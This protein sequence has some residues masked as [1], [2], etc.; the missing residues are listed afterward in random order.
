MPDTQT[1]SVLDEL[2]HELAASVRRASSAAADAQ[3]VAQLDVMRSAIE[4]A[5]GPIAECMSVLM[6][7]PLL[8]VPEE[9]S[10]TLAERKEWVAAQIE[11]LREAFASDPGSI[12]KASLWRDTKNAFEKLRDELLNARAA[13]YESLVDGFAAGD[14]ELLQTL[15]PRTA[16]TREYREAI[17][18][19]NL[20]RGRLPGTVEDVAKAA[21]AG[22]RLRALREQVESAA[23]PA[24]FQEQWRALRAD[25]LA[26]SKL[27]PEFRGWLD[28]H[29]LS[30]SV[31]LEYRAQ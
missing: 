31:V 24:E 30:R 15:P 27:T 10:A 26:L 7:S 1:P 12:R 13:S 16:G 23:V 2:A 25:G 5:T 14:R 3:L 19:F 17:E 18:N 22:R 8:N 20:I 9:Q 11:K 28:E 21:A 29:S 4:A 6:G